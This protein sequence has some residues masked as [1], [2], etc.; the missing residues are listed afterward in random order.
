MNFYRHLA[1]AGVSLVSLASAAASAQDVQ[2]GEDHSLG[3]S[4]EI[5]VTARRRDESAQ[6]VPLVVNAVTSESLSRLNIREFTDVQSVVPGLVI[7]PSAN[8]TLSAVSIRGVQNEGNV[9]GNNPSLQF[10]LNEAPVTSAALFTSMFDVGQIEVL[11]GPQGT[12]RGRTSPSGALTVTTMRP[13]LS[14]VG[15]YVSLTGASRASINANGAVGLP[16][17]PGVL[18]VRVAGIYDQGQPSTIRSLNNGTKPYFDTSGQRVSVRFDPLDTLSINGSF[19][20]VIRN[21]RSFDQVESLGVALP[22]EATTPIL[23]APPARRSLESVP[24][25]LR[26]KLQTWNWQADW[27]VSGQR[28]VYIGSYSKSAFRSFTPADQGGLLAASTTEVRAAG[29]D[30][31]SRQREESHEL[32][33]QSEE[34][35]AGIFDYVVG[36]FIYKTDA[37][38]DLSSSIVGEFGAG[39]FLLG[40]QYVVRTG[41]QIERS[42]FGNI[43]AHIGDFTEISGGLRYISYE[44][45]STTNVT[46]DVPSFGLN[47]GFP[48]APFAAKEHAWVYNASAKHRFNESLMAYAT[49]ASSWRPAPST[50]QIKDGNAAPSPNEARL[51]G[52]LPPER[53]TSY[54]IGFKS[55]W[56]DRRLRLN[57][58]AFHQEFQNFYVNTFPYVLTSQVPLPSGTFGTNVTRTELAAPVPVR[59]NGAEAEISFQPNRQL[60]LSANLAYALSKVKNSAVPCNPYPTLPP[61]AADFPAGQTISLCQ[62]SYRAQVTPP[63]SATVQA[64][65]TM[66]ISDKA[67]AFLRGLTTFYGNSQNNPDNQIDDVKSYALA[68]LYAGIRDPRGFWEVSVFAKNLFDVER[69]LSR[70]QGATAVSFNLSTSVPSNY[71]GITMNAPREFGLSVRYAFGSR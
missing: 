42:L 12:L 21:V 67:D 10:Y 18:A 51:L 41:E 23:I 60:S 16:V 62:V 45:Q 61:T 14:N 40:N 66:P 49:I 69:V 3:Q 36:G 57:V 70:A 71:R 56:F 53:S 46:I 11:R 64:E 27:R 7:S 59:V 26:Q 48:L 15:G 8:V 39:P 33:L 55:D 29:Q 58:S 24:N 13:D 4:Y 34:R 2:A 52:T 44:E 9:N 37:P 50:N 19:T 68:N 35:V 25:R 30:T 65:Y 28:V 31:D 43:T 22:G 5:V 6:D 20:N 47:F 38:T 54:E 1:C 32:R 63:F 17:V